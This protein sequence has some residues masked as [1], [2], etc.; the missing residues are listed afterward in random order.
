MLPTHPRFVFVFVL[1]ISSVT[2]ALLPLESLENSCFHVTGGE[3]VPV[4]SRKLVQLMVTTFVG[5][6]N[7]ECFCVQLRHE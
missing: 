5:A 6:T 1:C 3:I 2:V 7:V 4:Q